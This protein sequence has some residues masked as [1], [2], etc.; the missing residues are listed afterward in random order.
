M[1]F[2]M[3]HCMFTVLRRY[4]TRCVAGLA[5]FLIWHHAAV[6]AQTAG[7]TLTGR[8]VDQTG[9]AVPG[10]TISVT[11]PTTG[12]TRSVAT[13]SDGTYSIPSVPVGS[14]DVKA[15]LQGFRPVGQTQPP[16]L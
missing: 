4:R 13:E 9:A 15:T 14:Y 2:P 12:F 1:W 16:S 3:E 10:A 8:V 7:A 5:V 6:Y 11:S